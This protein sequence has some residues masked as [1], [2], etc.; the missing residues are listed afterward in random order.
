MQADPEDVIRKL[1]AWGD[2][3]PQLGE[4]GKKQSQIGKRNEPSG[5]LEKGK[6]SP[7]PLLRLASLA[8]PS[9]G[10][11]RPPIFFFAQADYFLLFSQ[12]RSL[13]PG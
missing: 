8:F 13:V 5:G 11:L 7:F 2:H 6:G 9:V 12:M 3:T 10:S 1:L 4:K